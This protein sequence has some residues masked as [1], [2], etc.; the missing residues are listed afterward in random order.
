[1]ASAGLETVSDFGKNYCSLLQI[2]IVAAGTWF[3]AGQSMIS[4]DIQN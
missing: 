3:G 2:S 4:G 1:V